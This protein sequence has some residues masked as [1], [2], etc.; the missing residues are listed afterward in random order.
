MQLSI[1]PMR[2][3][4]PT[5]NENGSYS[6]KGSLAMDH[7]GRNGTTN[8]PLYAPYDGVASRVRTD[9]SH[10][11][12]FV[13]TGNVETPCGYT[14]IVTTTIMHDDSLNV[15][16]GQLLSQG[17]HLADEGGFGRGI[18]EY[19]DAHSHIEAS[20]GTQTRQIQNGF[21]V[22]MT[23]NQMHLYDAF[24]LHPDTQVWQ[25]KTKS[26]IRAGDYGSSIADSYGNVWK[27]ADINEMN[28]GE[29][30]KDNAFSPVYGIDVSKHQGEINWQ[31]V[32]ESGKKFVLIR[33]GWSWYDGGLDADVNFSKNVQQALAA[34]LDVGGYIYAYD[35]T[36]EAAAIAADLAAKM[37][38]PYQ[39]RYPIFYDQEYEPCI[40]AL[41]K[42]RR[43]DNCLA[44][45]QEMEKLGY[46]TGMYASLDW[47]KNWVDDSRLS[48]FDHWVAQYGSECTYSGNFQLWQY[49]GSAGRCN[50]VS[51]ACDLNKCFID[52]PKKIA[53]KGLNGLKAPENPEWEILENK[54]ITAISEH[55]E[56]FS[57]PDIYKIVRKLSLGEQLSAK[58][59]SK[60]AIGPYIFVEV[61]GGYVANI[62][63]NVL[64]E[65]KKDAVTPE[66]NPQEP[67]KEETLPIPTDGDE[68]YLRVTTDG[69]R[70]RSTPEI[71]D[72]NILAVLKKNEKLRQW[73][74]RGS[75]ICV[76]SVTQAGWVHSNYVSLIKV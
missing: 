57:E 54:I 35:L 47:F 10:E 73:A 61:D 74:A 46:A 14:G 59:I 38:A 8:D 7:G 25:P 66:K 4:R 23:P 3:L 58:A 64:I 42:V 44:F 11:I 33:I 70:L 5:Q 18:A 17:A 22:Y 20:R 72:G 6:H 43:T 67:E 34:G 39:F 49:A 19:F 16:T 41:D 40:K 52:Y 51:G 1:F 71:S 69:L 31:A 32:K 56:L 2:W 28:A 60:N 30:M 9:S 45:M 15:A 26:W 55:C 62:A 75:W 13:S 63:E 76:S 48:S 36:P 12:Y 21:N 50:G 53:E 24:Y 29:E 68:V 37:C 65:D 27:V